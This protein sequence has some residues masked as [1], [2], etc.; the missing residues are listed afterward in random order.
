ML[1]IKRKELSIYPVF[2]A[3]IHSQEIW[4]TEE[5]VEGHRK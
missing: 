5:Q 4:G 1:L 2:R 3:N